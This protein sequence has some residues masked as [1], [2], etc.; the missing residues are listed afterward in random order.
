MIAGNSIPN[1]GAGVVL[2]RVVP[3]D[4]RDL[5]RGDYVILGYDITRV[6]PDGVAGLPHPM[7]QS[8]AL[9]WKGRTVYVT[10][11]PEGDGQ[12]YRGGPVGATPPSPGTKFIQGTLVDTWRISFGIESFF[13]QEGKGKQYEDAIREHRLWAEVALSPSGKAAL[14][15]LRIE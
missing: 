8:N 13:V 14:R 5:F 11:E 15:G 7:V 9:E 4:P 2:L 12:H 6:P 10:L 1:R 3:V